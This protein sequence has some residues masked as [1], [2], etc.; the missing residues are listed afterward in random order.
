MSI[1]ITGG[2]GFAGSHLVDL[3]VAQNSG[4]IHVTHFKGGIPTNPSF[5]HVQT[6]SLDI[7]DAT[8][9]AELVAEIKPTQIY[10]LAS[11]AFVGKSFE[12]GASLLTN[13]IS[14]QLNLFEAVAKYAPAARV[15]SI[16]SAEEYGISV[17][18]DEIPMKEDHP[19][20][21]INPYAVS[22]I[23]Q[24]M[25]A[26]AYA[27]SYKLQVLRVRPF[28]HIGPRQTDD[29]AVS[30]FAKQ[31]VAIE[32]G[33]QKV[34]QV[35]NLSGVRD[36]T[37]VRDM[38]AAYALIMQDGIP[39]EVYNVG[40]GV[41]VSMQEIV[42]R[43][44]AMATVPITIESDPSRLRPLDIPVIIANN[45]KVTQL[46]WKQN[47]PLEESLRSVVEYWRSV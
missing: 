1:L 13:N 46:G 23:A 26:Y 29:F 20:R 3:L 21:P 12:K 19:F 7:T 37:D 47:V 42:D 28:N 9:T 14:L 31:I 36:F 44:C 10:H 8:A 40:S 41:G 35:G 43:L 2:T 17:S 25:L 39:G 38:V 24:D 16:G 18:P 30:A 27:E 34:L 5:E 4:Q 33:E 11:F 6:H 32:R 15:I 22:K 45:E